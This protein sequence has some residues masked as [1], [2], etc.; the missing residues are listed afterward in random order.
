[1]YIYQNG[2]LYLQVGDKLVGVEIYSDQVLCIDG[3]D[4]VLEENHLVLSPLEVRCK[5]QTDE[6]P[7]IFPKVEG[8]VKNDTVT[9]PKRTARKS[10]SK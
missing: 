9:T 4:T 8:V 5:F 2:K 7:Y 10:T 3:Y 6:H 1:M